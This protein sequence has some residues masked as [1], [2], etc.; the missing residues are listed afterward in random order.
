MYIATQYAYKVDTCLSK[1]IVPWVHSG[2][3]DKSHTFMHK[4]TQSS[5]IKCTLTQNTL[6]EQSL[7]SL[8]NPSK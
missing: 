5:I 4:T 7:P 2:M 8:D 3:I 6:I 1:L